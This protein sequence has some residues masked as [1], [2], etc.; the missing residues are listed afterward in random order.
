MNIDISRR[1][2]LQVDYQPEEVIFLMMCG[3]SSATADLDQFLPNARRMQ[4]RAGLI[5]AVLSFYEKPD[6]E[7]TALLRLPVNRLMSTT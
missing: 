5:D 7:L 1:F 4:Q 6:G 3:T 2:T